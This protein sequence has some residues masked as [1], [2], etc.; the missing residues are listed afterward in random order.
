MFPAIPEAR[1]NAKNFRDPI[2][3]S[4]F[5][6][7]NRSTTMLDSKCIEPAWRNW[8]VTNR[9]IFSQRSAG[10]LSI[11]DE[12]VNPRLEGMNAYFQTNWRRAADPR[13]DSCKNTKTFMITRKTNI[14]L[15]SSSLQNH[16]LE[17]SDELI[18]GGKTPK[19][20]LHVRLRAWFK[21]NESQH[22]C[23]NS[24]LQKTAGK[25]SAT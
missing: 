12:P 6:P 16:T 3:S 7:R 25:S 1:E 13:F 14:A 2:P 9:E 23:F 24:S 20:T 5:F 11:V 21:I 10:A 4:I 19:R 17:R 15:T 8:L 18:A 22:N